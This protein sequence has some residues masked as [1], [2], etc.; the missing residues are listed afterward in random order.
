MPEVSRNSLFADTRELSVWKADCTLNKMRNRE[1]PLEG[2]DK[3]NVENQSDRRGDARIVVNV[4][5]EIMEVNDK[6]HQITERTFIEDVSDFGC[7]FSILGTVK[8]GDT[9][10]IR[11]LAQDG[12]ALLDEPARV[13]EVMWV[14]HR[15]TRWVVGARILRGEKFDKVK[16]LQESG[17]PKLPA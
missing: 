9:V 15:T 10:A 4:P 2:N 16:I 7:R 8:K 14:A 6:G 1:N 13:F 3:S 5:V 17:G 11:L 12:K